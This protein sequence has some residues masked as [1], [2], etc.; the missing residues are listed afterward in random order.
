MCIA[1]V[2]V[3]IFKF[4]IYSYYIFVSIKCFFVQLYT[5]VSSS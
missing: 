4:F 1:H 2:A 5:L 3:G